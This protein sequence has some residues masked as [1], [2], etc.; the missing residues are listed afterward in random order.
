MKNLIHYLR[1]QLK[2]SSKI[3]QSYTVVVDE[4]T[5]ATQVAVIILGPF[6]TLAKE[7]GCPELLTDYGVQRG[8][9]HIMGHKGLVKLRPKY[10]GI[11]R[12]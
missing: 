6:G 2:L 9:Q 7:Q 8:C 11:L 3:F 5:D 4:S 1:D 12:A 10:I